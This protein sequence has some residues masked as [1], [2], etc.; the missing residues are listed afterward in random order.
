[1]KFRCKKDCPRKRTGKL[2]FTAGKEYY[3][4]D[5]PGY[6]VIDNQGC[7][8][9]IAWPGDPFFDKHFEIVEEEK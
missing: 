1:M 5:E 4:D 8:Y 2:A 9:F 6:T 7:D 3:Q